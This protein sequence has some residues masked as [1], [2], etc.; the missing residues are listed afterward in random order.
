MAQCDIKICD[1][2][3]ARWVNP[4]D[5]L[6]QQQMTEYVVTRWYR[7]PEILLA[8]DEY[9]TAIDMWSAGCILAELYCRRPL[10][11]GQDTKNQLEVICNKLGK[12]SEEETE[13]I[14]N[15]QARAFIRALPDSRRVD[16]RRLMG[17][18]APEEAVDLVEQMLRFDARKRITAEQALGH[19]FVRDYRDKKAETVAGKIDCERLEPPSERKLGRDGVRRLMWDEMLAFHP[20][21]RNREPASAKAA[22]RKVQSLVN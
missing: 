10:F 1:F 7:A 13:R 21:A 2:G 18:N 11:P 9:T 16:L 4:E 17:G 8:T 15:K 19:A 3:L 14:R 6:E 5:E 20:D 22:E 12:P